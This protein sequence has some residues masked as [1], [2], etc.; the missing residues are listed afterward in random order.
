MKKIAI[1]TLNGYFNYGNRLQNYALQ[2][3]LSSFGY[4]VQTLRINRD[5]HAD[6]FNSFLKEIK[7]WIKNPSAYYNQKHRQSV[8]LEFSHRY[9]IETEMVFNMDDDLTH[10]NR[11]FDYFVVGSD[12]VWNPSMNRVSSFFFLDFVEENKRIAYAPSFGIS[13]LPDEV[14][15]DYQKWIKEIPYLSV[16]EDDGTKIIKNLTGREVSV[17]VDPTVLLTKEKWINVSR[18][19]KNKPAEEYLLT[20]FLG[21]I[22]KEYKKQINE[23]AN[24]KGLK[25]MNLGDKNEK[26]TYRTGPSE[27]IDYIKDCS[28]FCTD[29]FHGAVFSILMEKPFIVYE[30]KGAVSMYSRIDTLLNKFDLSERKSDN[31]E[32]NEKVFEIDF[33][34]TLSILEKERELAINFLKNALKIE[35]AN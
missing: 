19:A 6:K 1:A 17:L 34:H 24:V 26:D 11:E 23:I 10:L 18:V 28:V 13:K 5:K 8:F 32:I 21:G 14:N 30:R 20:Y 25:I 4:E 16:R 15:S 2:E 7:R 33:S 9:I 35:D 31:I 3:V 29:S 27:F 12:Q 22:P